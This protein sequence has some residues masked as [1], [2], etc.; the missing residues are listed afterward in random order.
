[1]KKP[2]FRGSYLNDYILD[3]YKGFGIKYPELYENFK[4]KIIARIIARIWFIRV[5]KAR[6][7]KLAYF[8]ASTIKSMESIYEEWRIKSGI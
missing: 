3:S 2:A 5:Q 4:Q 7:H 8:C 6:Q 1:M